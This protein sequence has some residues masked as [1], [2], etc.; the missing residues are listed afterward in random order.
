MA[1]GTSLWGVVC[2][3][4]S[5]SVVSNSVWPQG[6]W[7]ARLLCPRDSPGKN[8]GVG[9][10][11]L[12]QGV[13]R[14]QGLHTAGRFFTIWATRTVV[15]VGGAGRT[16]G[17]ELRSRMPRASA[18]EKEKESCSWRFYLQL[19]LDIMIQIQEKKELL[20]RM[21]NMIPKDHLQGVFK[22]AWFQEHII[23]TF[24]NLMALQCLFNSGT[25]IL[26]SFLLSPSP[27]NKVSTLD[28]QT[29]SKS[30]FYTLSPPPL[31][32]PLSSCYVFFW[33]EVIF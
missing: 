26:W 22:A 20:Y 29:R 10:H 30:H 15:S 5:R 19:I 14:I 27:S 8:T 13:F 16:P 1:P 7:P 21:K 9:C 24:C 25:S 4:V 31:F 6:L 17:Q 33:E 28:E 23:N 11:F 32:L 2:V 3:R 12:L 18:K